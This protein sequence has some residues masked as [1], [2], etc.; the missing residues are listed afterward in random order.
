MAVRAIPE[1]HEAA[2]PYLCVLD[3]P[4]M[5]EFYKRV[6]GA[7]EVSRMA[8]PDGRVGHAEIR[9]GKALIMLSD[10]HPEMGIL[11][12]RTIGKARSPVGIHLYVEDVDALYKRALQAGATSL[13]EP[14]DQF[15]GDRNAQLIDPSGHLWYI[16]TRKEDVSPAEMTRRFDALTKQPPK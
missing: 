5:I 2:V 1:G 15:Y 7:T 8:G 3:A 13:R 16:S 14:Q 12:P 11:S 10:E 6:F 9:I 4:K